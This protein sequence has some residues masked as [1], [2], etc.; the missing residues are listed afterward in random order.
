MLLLG[1]GAAAFV[2]AYLSA[3]IGIGGGTLFIVL[4]YLMLPPAIALPL[5][6]AVQVLN[7]G[8]RYLVFRQYVVWR[9]ARPF[10]YSVLPAVAL[11]WLLLGQLNPDLL[12]GL[13]GLY[14]LVSAIR[15]PAQHTEPSARGWTGLGAAAGLSSMLVGVADPV[16][17]PYFMSERYRREQVIA[18]KAICQLATHVPKVLLFAWLGRNAFQFNYGDYSEQ[19]VFMGAAVLV[20]ILLGKKSKISEQVFRRSYRFLLGLLGIKLVIDA[21][22]TLLSA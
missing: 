16:I 2:A 20:G 5:H 15:P 9:V 4:L 19:L 13:L 12:K 11:G 3:A 7:N 8:T 18:T 21:A 22:I 1:L 6:G 17:A 14:V 10:L